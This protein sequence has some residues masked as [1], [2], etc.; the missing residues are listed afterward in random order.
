MGRID[1]HIIATAT[2]VAVDSPSAPFAAVQ[3]FAVDATIEPQ[4]N[5]T[6]I[7]ALLTQHNWP[8]GLQD[9]FVRN[10]KDISMRFI[11]CDDSGSMA[12]M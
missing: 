6:A 2:A 9:T 11:I 5:E 7:K 3:A 8:S 1:E 4:V 12:G 10:A